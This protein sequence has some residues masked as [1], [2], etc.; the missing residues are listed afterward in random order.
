MKE[1]NLI[2]LI[3]EHNYWDKNLNYG[4]ITQTLSQCDMNAG[5]HRETRTLAK[6]LLNVSGVK[7]VKLAVDTICLTVGE[8]ILP[9]E[10]KEIS[11]KAKVIAEEIAR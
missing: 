3:G 11:E 1:L 10:V 9:E 5:G 4:N 7:H 8:E 2:M 6:N